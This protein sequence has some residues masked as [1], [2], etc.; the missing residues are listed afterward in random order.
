MLGLLGWPVGETHQQH[1]HF[2]SITTPPLMNS[3]NMGPQNGGHGC[4]LEPGGHP[5]MC[6]CRISCC[7]RLPPSNRPDYTKSRCFVTSYGH[8]QREGSPW[9]IRDL[10]LKWL[11]NQSAASHSALV[12]LIYIEKVSGLCEPYPKLF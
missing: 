2:H 5:S 10:T 9:V 4:G 1:S 11:P 3:V 8:S 6:G 12:M 7:Q